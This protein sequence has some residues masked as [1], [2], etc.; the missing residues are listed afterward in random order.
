MSIR[1]PAPCTYDLLLAALLVDIRVALQNDDGVYFP[2]K[3]PVISGSFVINDLQ[4]AAVLIDIHIPPQNDHDVY[5]PQKSPTIGGSS[6]KIDL[7]F[8]ASYR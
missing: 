7:Q 1:I 5:F 8:K 4:L 2:Q 6:A 3:S